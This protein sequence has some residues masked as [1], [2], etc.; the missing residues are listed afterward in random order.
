MKV[1]KMKADKI[2]IAPSKE[3]AA[4]RVDFYKKHCYRWCQQ[5]LLDL[6]IAGVDLSNIESY[7]TSFSRHGDYFMSPHPYTQSS[8]SSITTEL[9]ASYLEAEMQAALKSTQISIAISQLNRE[10]SNRE[11]S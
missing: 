1:D 6:C 5:S 9:C 8:I 10:R 4:R 7:E 2:F 11:I 3:E